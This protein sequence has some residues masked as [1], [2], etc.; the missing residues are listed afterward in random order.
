MVIAYQHY[1]PAD[2]AARQRNAAA[3]ATWQN[4]GARLFP[5]VGDVTSRFIGDPRGCPFV[6]DIIDAAV[7][8]GPERII[9][10]TNNDILIGPGLGDAI[11]ESCHNY[12][13]Y[14]A[15]R[16][17]HV[18]GQPDGGRDLFAMTR[19]WWL[20]VGALF[21]DLLIGYYYWDVIMAKLMEWGG[22]PE[23]PRLYFHPPHPGIELRQ[24]SPGQ[25]YNID[26]AKK[27]LKDQGEPE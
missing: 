3:Y 15:Y 11:R 20:Q 8:S 7:Q 18:G 6:A 9:I 25:R 14:W 4:S 24:N 13:C 22:C 2:A 26:T 17:P 5:F 19:S 1:T 16:V 10:I 27:W 21:P 12:G 23:G